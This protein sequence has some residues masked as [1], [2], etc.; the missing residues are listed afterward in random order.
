MRF[1]VFW[2]LTRNQILLRY[3]GHQIKV[4]IQSYRQQQAK[5]DRE[6]IDTLLILDTPLVKE[7]WH[8]M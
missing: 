7:A 1:Y 5:T 2:D 6:D 3:L 4:S 8:R